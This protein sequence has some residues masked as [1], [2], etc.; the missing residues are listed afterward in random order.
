[1]VRRTHW[2]PGGGVG[3][4][5]RHRWIQHTLGFKNVFHIIPI[6]ENDYLQV[7]FQIIFANEGALY[8]AITSLKILGRNVKT[9]LYRK[10]FC[11]VLI[12][13]YIF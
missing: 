6:L 13:I 3:A 1:M 10:I 11:L 7:R 9:H 5:H 12:K 8:I 2:Q 4:R